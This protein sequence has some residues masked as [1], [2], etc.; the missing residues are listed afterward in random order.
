MIVFHVTVSFV[1]DPPFDLGIA[2]D[3]FKAVDLIRN[4]T[5][6]F[7]RW[8]VNAWQVDGDFVGFA[9]GARGDLANLVSLARF[10]PRTA[11]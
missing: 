7:D 4:A 3:A 8:A 9:Q 1:D 2:S 11:A 10:V 6:G 5:T